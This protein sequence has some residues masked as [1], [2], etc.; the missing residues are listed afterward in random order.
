EQKAADRADRRARRLAQGRS[1]KTPGSFH[2]DRIRS[3]QGGRGGTDPRLREVLRPGAEGQGR[4]KPADRRDDADR[5]PQ[6]SGF[7]GGQGLQGV[8]L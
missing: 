2:G 3:A 4:Q 1:R 8:H 7:Q 5:C 6:G